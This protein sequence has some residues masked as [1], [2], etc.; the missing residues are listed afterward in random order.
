MALLVKNL[1]ANAGDDS[2]IPGTGRSPGGGIGNLFSILAWKIPWIKELG[3]L[4][5]MVLQESDTTEHA[6]IHIH[7]YMESRNIVLMNLFAGQE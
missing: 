4:Q 2:L 7:A 1:P 3:G 5:S 6:H